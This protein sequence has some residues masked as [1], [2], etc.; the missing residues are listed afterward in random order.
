ML[1]PVLSTELADVWEQIR[2]LIVSVAER[3]GGRYS[4]RT[5][6]EAILNR[7]WQLWMAEGPS[8]GLTTLIKYPTGMTACHFVAVVGEDREGWLDTEREIEAW[9]REQ[10][11]SAVETMARRGWERVLKARGWSAPHVFMERTFDA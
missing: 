4:E 9:A 8:I 3:S 1:R 6:A 7:D 5:I 10:G 2:P 11:A